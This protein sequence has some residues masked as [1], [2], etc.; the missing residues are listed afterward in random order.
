MFTP[1]NTVS[2]VPFPLAYTFQCALRTHQGP[3]EG[4]VV[5]LC[6]LAQRSRFPAKQG[7]AGGRGA[8]FWYIEPVYGLIGSPLNVV[9]R[10]TLRLLLSL[11]VCVA[12]LA[13]TGTSWSAPQAC[14]AHATMDAMAMMTNCQRS[15]ATRHAPTGQL[16]KATAA[17]NLTVPVFSTAAGVQDS[18][19]QRFKYPRIAAHFVLQDFPQTL[20]RP[21]RLA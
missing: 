18:P 8:H 10:A 6:A 19:Y 15:D 5:V 21:P 14:P 20:L 7:D 2:D 12:F 3:I 11:L 1:G 17:C 16:C 9:M 4:W 13:Q